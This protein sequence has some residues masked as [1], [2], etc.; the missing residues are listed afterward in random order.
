M[1]GYTTQMYGL[2]AQFN[3]K[4]YYTDKYC[5]IYHGDCL[6]IMPHLEPVD[7]VLTDPPYGVNKAKWDKYP[8]GSLEMAWGKTLSAMLVFWS[9]FDLAG[10]ASSFSNGCLKNTIIWAKPNLP[11]LWMFDRSRLPASYEP[12]FYHAKKGYEPQERPPDFWLINKLNQFQS[13]HPTQKPTE[14][15]GKCLRVFGGNTILDPFMGSGT[16]L[17]AAKQLRRKSIGIEIEEKYCEIAVR[18]LAQ[19]VIEFG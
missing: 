18:R 8:E 14:I 10:I 4:P 11:C 16:T 6:D 17:V 5:T 12:I 19:E 7:L 2:G 1:G 3:M 9:A 13:Q 15:I